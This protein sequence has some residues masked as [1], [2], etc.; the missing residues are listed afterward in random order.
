MK[1]FTKYQ[2]ILFLLLF[3]LIAVQTIAQRTIIL[4][5]EFY[6]IK[7]VP[8]NRV[9]RD[10]HNLSVYK[11][12]DSSYNNILKLGTSAIP[13]LI[14]KM[15][16]TSLTNISNPC[17]NDQLMRYGDLAWFIITDIEDIPLFTVTK[18]QWCVW[19]I[20]DHFPLGFFVSLNFYRDKF[21]KQYEAY[22][23]SR[24]R[25]KILKQRERLK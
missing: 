25:K 18:N 8:I 19:G 12:M 22:F 2:P 11:Q 14:S 10:S 6:K 5:G 7:S 9:N 21:S 3:L 17:D 20:C 23:Y 13:F 24:E 16:D 1:E 15:R 4:D